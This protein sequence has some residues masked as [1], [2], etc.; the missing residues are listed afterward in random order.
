MPILLRNIIL[1]I[2]DNL[3]PNNSLKDNLKKSGWS[4]AARTDKGVHAIAN[5][6]NCKLQ[7]T[8][9]Y[10]EDESSIEL[11]SSS[12]NQSENTENPNAEPK[13]PDGLG[14]EK[15]KDKT[16]VDI[17]KLITVINSNLN[18]DIKV[19]GNNKSILLF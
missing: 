2:I 13:R 4:R 9:D 11:T 10:L 17:K 8:K 12:M 1:V 15:I 3:I 18:D 19:F 7:I 16:R 6:I 14:L 5:F